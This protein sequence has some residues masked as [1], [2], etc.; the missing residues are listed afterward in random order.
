M[1]GATTGW[2]PAACDLGF[3]VLGWSNGL[4]ML[5]HSL[6]PESAWWPSIPKPAGRDL[7]MARWS[8]NTSWKLRNVFQKRSIKSQRALHIYIYYTVKPM[9]WHEMDWRSHRG[10]VPRDFAIHW[11]H[12]RQMVSK[13]NRV[14]HR[15]E[16]RPD[17]QAEQSMRFVVSHVFLFSCFSMFWLPC[18]IKHWHMHYMHA[19]LPIPNDSFYPQLID[20]VSPL[21]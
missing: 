2:R 16:V 8:H 3:F 20:E 1:T 14:K 4:H 18:A 15:S 7:N 6:P 13:S 17:L 12:W 19:E 9:K 21:W 10:E 11:I 5:C